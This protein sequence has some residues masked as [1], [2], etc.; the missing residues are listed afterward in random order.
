MTDIIDVP[1]LSQDEIL[2]KTQEVRMSMINQMTAEGVPDNNRDRR[3]MIELLTSTD[4][5]ALALKRLTQDEKI[6]GEDNKVALLAAAMLSSIKG[7][8]FL[9]ATPLEN[10]AVECLTKGKLPAVELV[11]GE[12]DIGIDNTTY[13]EFIANHDAS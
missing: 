2:Q 6:A 9:T 7:N 11:K 5:T 3:V 8:P 12:I 1:A 10:G 13:D 4:S